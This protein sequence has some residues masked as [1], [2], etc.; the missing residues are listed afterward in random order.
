MIRYEAGY[1]VAAPRD[2]QIYEPPSAGIAEPGYRA[3]QIRRRDDRGSQLHVRIA[4]IFHARDA[5][6]VFVEIGLW[7][8][9]RL[10]GS[11]T[12]GE[13]FSRLPT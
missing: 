12:K 6:N 4:S 13:S 1:P 8:D 9:P 7:S 10:R 3:N 2:Q 11:P 5:Q